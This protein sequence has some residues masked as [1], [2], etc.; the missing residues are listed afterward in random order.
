MKIEDFEK[1]LNKSQKSLEYSFLHNVKTYCNRTKYRVVK[2][3]KATIPFVITSMLSLPFLKLFDLGYPVI[4]DEHKVYN[5]NVTNIETNE[6]F[7]DYVN[8]KQK[9]FIKY[10]FPYTYINGEYLR[11]T[12]YY[13]IDDI[14]NFK[15]IDDLKQIKIDYEYKSYVSEED[16][17]KY[18][19]LYYDVNEEQYK[20]VKESDSKNLNVSA[21]Y[22]TASFISLI[23]FLDKILVTESQNTDV[24]KLY[25]YVK[26]K[27]VKLLEKKLQMKNKNLEFLK[28]DINED[29]RSK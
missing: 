9:T 2:Y 27:D 5:Y 13:E 12:I 26:K 16:K 7:N 20:M 23:Y 25:P 11:Q 1:D 24:D 29:E 28:G 15:S 21:A 22:F 19:I 14:E 17:A 6:T 8:I 10:N 3:K 18:E 4:E